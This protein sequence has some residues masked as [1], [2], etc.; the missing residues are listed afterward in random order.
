MAQKDD[1]RSP[2][3][4]SIDSSP[5]D[6]LV[7]ANLKY[8]R[9]AAGLTQTALGRAID[10]SGEAIRLYESGAHRLRAVDML[11]LCRTLDAK[12][13]DFFYGRDRTAGVIDD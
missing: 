4:L 9:E 3:L 13:E 10:A 11:K 8:L 6:R 2:I 5:V 12:A 7:G 1:A